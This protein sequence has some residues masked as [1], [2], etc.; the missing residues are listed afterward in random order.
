MSDFKLVVE[1][2]GLQTKHVFERSHVIKRFDD[3]T[4]FTMDGEAL[5]AISLVIQAQLK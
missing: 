2:I 3:G 4:V 5:Y 1:T